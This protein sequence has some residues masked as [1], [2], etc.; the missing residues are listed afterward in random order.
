MNAQLFELLDAADI[1][2]LNGTVVNDIRTVH[3]GP[4]QTKLRRLTYNDSWLHFADQEVAMI[5]GE[6]HAVNYLF[7]DE[8][9]P[10]R[11]HL[12]FLKTSN[13]SAHDLVN[14]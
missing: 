2:Y 4:E 8:F 7:T 6:A 9:P 11:V 3:A 10:E 12:L 14:S 5:D 13:L 1:V